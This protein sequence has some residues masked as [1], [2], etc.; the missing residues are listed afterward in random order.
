VFVPNKLRLPQPPICSVA[1]GRPFLCVVSLWLMAGIGCTATSPRVKPGPSAP[2]S[3][4]TA[5]GAAATSAQ[6]P[7]LPPCELQRQHETEIRKEASLRAKQ[8][9]KDLAA[10]DLE[11]QRSELQAELSQLGSRQVTFGSRTVRLDT[12]SDREQEM[13]ALF[14]QFGDGGRYARAKAELTA[15]SQTLQA[16]TAGAPLPE[17]QLALEVDFC[18]EDAF[19]AWATWTEEAYYAPRDEL[20]TDWTL[21]RRLAIARITQTGKVLLAREFPSFLD[22]VQADQRYLPPDRTNCC[23]AFYG[24]GQ[25]Q[26]AFTHD[27]TG[28]GIPELGLEASFHVEGSSDQSGIVY[29]VQGDKIRVQQFAFERTEDVDKDGRLDLVFVDKV[30]VGEQCGSG[31]PVEAG[32]GEYLAHALKDGS[33]SF[34]D[35]IAVAYGRAQCPKAPT[36]FDSYEAIWCGKVWKVPTSTILAGRGH[37]CVADP[38]S[39]N[40]GEACSWFDTA[41]SSFQPQLTLSASDSASISPPTTPR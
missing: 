27:Q 39:S 13:A 40:G 8:R 30:V 14:D 41:E 19:G 1:I 38:C 16:L 10:P 26:V 15:L 22:I 32:G 12:L 36:S 21:G 6:S 31:F 28:D 20:S 2:Q 18:V 3:A 7:H 4:T 37:A 33:Y 11:R 25:P 9:L 29:E 23:Y 24:Q 5:P 34:D 35:P 17:D